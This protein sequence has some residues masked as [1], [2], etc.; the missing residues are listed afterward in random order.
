MN[1]TLPRLTF[2]ALTAVAFLARPAQ[3]QFADAPAPIGLA[4]ERAFGES[5]SLLMQSRPGYAAQQERARPRFWRLAGYGTLGAGAGAGVLLLLADPLREALEDDRPARRED[6]IGEA[7]ALLYLLPWI[8]GVTGTLAAARDPLRDG[9]SLL[10]VGGTSFF[11]SLLGVGL[12]VVVFGPGSDVG[13]ALGFAAGA[14]T[15]AALGYLAAY[16]QAH[17]GAAGASLLSVEDGRW[18][19]G[20]PAVRLLR[21]PVRSARAV[22]LLRVRL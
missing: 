5:Q 4:A 1:A 19:L 12:G 15:G 16:R 8:G 14:G 21:G 6:E 3:A 20:V 18:R 17:R 9:P 22:S 11:A 10:A 7:A 13:I 2:A